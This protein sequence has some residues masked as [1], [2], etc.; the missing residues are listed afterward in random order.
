MTVPLQLTYTLK[1][2]AHLQREKVY[3]ETNVCS[4][5]TILVSLVK[6]HQTGAGVPVRQE[7]C[8]DLSALR[9]LLQSQVHSVLL[10]NVRLA[11]KLI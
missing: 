8:I 6:R 1:P 4:T 2:V 9:L 7:T 3:D 5:K 10:R 11:E